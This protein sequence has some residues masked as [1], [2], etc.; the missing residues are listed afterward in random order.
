MMAKVCTARTLALGMLL[1][2]FQGACYYFKGIYHNV[3]CT[4]RLGYIPTDNYTDTSLR[5]RGCETATGER[6]L[7][8]AV[9]VY[10]LRNFF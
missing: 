9:F 5:Q 2:G 7:G 4:V 6:M 8:G 1:N 10:F 3:I